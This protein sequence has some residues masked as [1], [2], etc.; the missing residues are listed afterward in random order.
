[1]R[2]TSAHGG[3]VRKRNCQGFVSELFRAAPFESKI[4]TLDKHVG[5]DQ[6]VG[7]I[8]LWKDR[9]VIADGREVVARLDLIYELKLGSHG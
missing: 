8:I 3:D 6:E 9:A 4:D 7:L 1:L 5:G 2:S